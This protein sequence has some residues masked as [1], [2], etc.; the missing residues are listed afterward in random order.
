MA[1]S[2]HA[3]A[4]GAFALDQAPGGLTG[5]LV[6]SN[7]YNTFGTMN[8]LGIGT[9]QTGLT[10]AQLSNGAMYFSP[11]LIIFTGL[12]AGHKGGLTAYV[13]TQFG[14]PIALVLQNCPTSG[15]CTTSGS[16]STMSTSAA[17]PS[18]VIAAPGIGNNQ[19]VT[20]GIGIFLPDNDGAAAFTGTDSAIVTF[21]MTD[22][23]TKAVV[24]TAQFLLN[25]PPETVQTALQLTLATAPS[26]LAITPASDFAMNFGNV[27]ALGIGPGAGLS[28]VAAAGGI[29]YATPYWLNPVFTNF[30]S[31]SASISVYVSTNF[32]HPTILKLNDA[33]S[34]GGPYT[35]VSTTP[36]T[37]TQI[38]HAA[39]DRSTI[40]R[41][42]G[43]FVANTNGPTAFNGTDSA[44]LTFTLTVP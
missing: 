10:V 7:Y 5:T 1:A 16:Y 39:G 42:V 31:T 9:P 40:T 14:H 29:V 41:Y 26:G 34:S 32:A 37:P 13:S 43:L 4:Q 3:A 15:T 25:T 30:L 8:A 19:T 33:S 44:T 12:P 23:T 28:T 17:G 2:S 21:R 18:S 35:A 38:T 6:G 36:A 20:A 27:N 22:L 24:A 11:Y